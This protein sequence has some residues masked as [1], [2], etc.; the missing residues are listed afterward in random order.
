M[1]KIIPKH[2]ER[3]ESTVKRFKKFCEREGIIKE[4]KKHS[5]YEKPSDVRRRKALRSIRTQKKAEADR[6]DAEKPRRF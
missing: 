4:I 5:Y 1:H 2:G 3:I 6:L